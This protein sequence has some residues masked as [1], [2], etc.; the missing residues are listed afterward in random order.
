[1]PA[2]DKSLA[3]RPKTLHVHLE[4]AITR[5]IITL[6]VSS[7]HTK[8]EIGRLIMIQEGIPIDQ[9]RFV[10][11]GKQMCAGSKLGEYGVE[12][13]ATIHWILRLCGC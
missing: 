2:I 6:H 1:M 10:Y 8:E 5:K 4:S 9:M 12:D 7:E 11:A 3:T 13:G